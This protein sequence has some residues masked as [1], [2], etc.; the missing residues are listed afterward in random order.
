MILERAEI[1]DVVMDYGLSD[2]R[3]DQ[4]VEV[5]SRISQES[6]ASRLRK[7]QYVIS[8]EYDGVLTI[9]C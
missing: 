2:Q 8:R 3:F 6:S 1:C 4:M 5:N 9:R 7:L